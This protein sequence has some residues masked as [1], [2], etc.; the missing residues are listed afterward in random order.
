MTSHFNFLWVPNVR[1]ESR[2]RA[3]SRT[4]TRRLFDRLQASGLSESCHWWQFHVPGRSLEYALENPRRSWT[5][6]CLPMVEQEMTDASIARSPPSF[7]V[8]SGEQ[9]PLRPLPRQRCSIILQ[10]RF[11]G[12]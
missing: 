2:G 5:S 11:S 6:T 1:A 12:S 3:L 8:D 4:T 10:I 9:Y 7:L